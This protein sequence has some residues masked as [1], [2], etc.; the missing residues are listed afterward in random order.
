VFS[1]PDVQVTAVPAWSLVPSP[2][3]YN[4]SIIEFDGARL[5]AYRSHRMDQNG[6]CGI[7]ICEL[8]AKWHAKRN[9]WLNLPEQIRSVMVHHEDPRLFIFRGRL[10]VAFTETQFHGNR[11][12]T[13]VMK[14]ARLRRTRGRLAIERVFWPRYG[15][16][17]GSHQE[18]N[19]QFFEAAPGRLHVIYEAAPHTVFEIGPDG[20]TVVDVTIDKASRVRWPWGTI[21]GG[22]PPIRLPDGSWLTIFHSSSPH[23]FPPHWR[24]Y[25]AGAYTFLPEPPYTITSISQKPILT[26]SEEDGHAYDPRNVDSWKPFVVFPSGAIVKGGSIFVSYGVNDHLSVVGEHKDL[27]LGSPAFTDWGPKFFFVENGNTPIRIHVQED[28]PPEWIRWESVRNGGRAGVCP[29]VLQVSD[30]RV[31]LHIAETTPGLTE[32]SAE[33]YRSLKA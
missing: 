23:P 18:K 13:C 6:R 15:R 31:A 2:R 27:F 4:A 11:P 24:R 21:R 32:I 26:G 30:P 25:Y 7:V 1:Q 22:T 9:T 33:Q 14:Y 8:D 16:N 28:R 17:D 5:M 10:H 20:E 12:Y 3:N 29:G 19:W